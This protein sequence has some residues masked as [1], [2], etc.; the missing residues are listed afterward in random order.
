MPTEKNLKVIYGEGH[1][2]SAAKTWFSRRE[3][4]DLYKMD[5]LGAELPN[6]PALAILL[7]AASL[8][9]LTR[10]QAEI[11]IRD[12]LNQRF[13]NTSLHN[14]II[15]VKLEDL[16]WPKMGASGNSLSRTL[17]FTVDYS[18]LVTPS[19]YISVIVTRRQVCRR[20]RSR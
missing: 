15:A 13:K 16:K 3:S 17:P 6:S 9:Q 5:E 7:Q 8:L 4:R 14:T 18:E 12:A 2:P 20:S 10:P 11:M 1:C 19:K